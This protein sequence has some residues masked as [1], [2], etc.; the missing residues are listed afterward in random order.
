[1]EYAGIIIGL[2]TFILIGFLHIAVLKVEYH[3]GS[4]V[5]PVFAVLGV[6]FIGGSLFASDTVVSGMLGITGFLLAWSAPELIKQR[7]RVEKGW[8][9]KKD[10]C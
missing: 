6:L 8:Y 9:P 5:W 4:H 3:V 2:M 10:K 1:V 7:E